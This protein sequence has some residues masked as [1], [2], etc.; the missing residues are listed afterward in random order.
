M[1]VAELVDRYCAVWS[2]P[3]AAMR[4][5]LLD[6]LWSDGATY[7]DPG[8]HAGDGAALLEHISRVQAS[9]PGSTVVRT[10]AV[11]I[12]HGVARFAWRAMGGDGTPLVDGIDIAFINADGDRIER[13]IGFFGP[14]QSEQD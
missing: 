6:T 8:V 7:T 5:A 4:K 12:H 14:L 13:I 9:R 1:D 10:S 3:D 11:D 2:E